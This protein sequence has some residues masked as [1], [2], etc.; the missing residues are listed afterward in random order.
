L[1]ALRRRSLPVPAAAM[2]HVIVPG[3]RH[4]VGRVPELCV[5]RTRLP[6]PVST[7]NGVRTV[8]PAHA[9]VQSWPLVPGSDQRA[10]AIEAV[11]T[12]IV[13]VDELRVATDQA[14]RLSGRARLITL[15]DALGA[16]C[17][18]ELEL[19]GYLEVF[20]GPGLRH[21]VRQRL[22]HVG[23]RTYRLDLAYEDERVAVELDG[24]AYHSSAQ[25]RERDMRRD[26]A[27]S[28]AGW[29]TL[30]FSHQRLHHD[31]AGCR[32][33]TLATLAA[34]RQWRRSG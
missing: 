13:T 2:V 26:A 28:A 12:G 7:V 11:R 34:R 31:L 30:R 32:R 24:R 23:G 20:D 29:V 22:V 5:H 25:Q 17:E 19:W 27:L 15:I 4:P 6:T 3:G 33:D 10:A 18:S 14:S 21:A 16:G 8:A 1:S 9:I